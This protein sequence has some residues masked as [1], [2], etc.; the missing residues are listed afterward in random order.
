MLT[1]HAVSYFLALIKHQLGKQNVEEEEEEWHP[2]IR[3]RVVD[4]KMETKKGF[5]VDIVS[6]Q[7]ER[8]R[9]DRE[10]EVVERE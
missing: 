3:V 5:L 10:W 7:T 1:Q 2:W 9:E 8:K 6:K 4:E